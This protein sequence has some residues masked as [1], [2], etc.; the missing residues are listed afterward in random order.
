MIPTDIS[1]GCSSFLEN[2]DGDPSLSSCLAPLVSAVAAYGPG[3]DGT[4]S[5]LTTALG[6]LCSSTS[7]C[8]DST[9]RSTL[10]SFQS[11]C[12]NEL[13]TNENTRVVAIYDLLY[14]MIP[15]NQAIC[16]QDNNGKYCVTEPAVASSNDD[17]QKYLY[18]PVSSFSRRDSPASYIVNTTTWQTY[19][20]VFLGL[21]PSLS[22]AQLCVPCTRAIL[23]P[24]ITFESSL[25]YAPGLAQSTLLSGQPALYN[26]IQGTCGSDFLSGV[27]Q[28]AGGISGNGP[29]GS[30]NAASH[31]IAGDMA[32]MLGSAILG[33]VAL[34]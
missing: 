20:V 8:D 17:V 29:L 16:S 12:S 30:K 19:N 13:Q 4:S 1:S 2:L 15:F 9:I 23:S 33:L 14:T 18:E 24:Y 28:A 27:V 11:A 10:A 7:T 31:T 34:F 22:S 32:V 21:Q 6:T 25:P 26:A 3:G 5:S